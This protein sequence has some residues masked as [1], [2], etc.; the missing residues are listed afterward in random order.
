MGCLAHEIGHLFDLGH[1]AKGIMGQDY[2]NYTVSLYPRSGL[3]VDSTGKQ[4][5]HSQDVILDV[6]TFSR[7]SAVLLFF[8]RGFQ[9]E[10]K[11]TANTTI[12]EFKKNVIHSSIGV[13][14][15]ELRNTYTG[16]VLNSWTYDTGGI[17]IFKFPVTK[18]EIPVGYIGQEVQI[19]AQDLE[20]NILK[21]TVNVGSIPQTSFTKLRH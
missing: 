13:S 15:I 10:P 9:P 2:H 18:K 16:D 7:S 5:R 6:P 1:T 11:S 4:G 19:V 17:K 21:T 3:K 8:H 20:G 14:A 12:F